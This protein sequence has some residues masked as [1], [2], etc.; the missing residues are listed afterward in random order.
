MLASTAARVTFIGLKTQ[1]LV[2]ANVAF[3]KGYDDRNRPCCS[4]YLVSRDEYLAGDDATYEYD[5]S[6]TVVIRHVECRQACVE[7]L[8]ELSDDLG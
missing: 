1:Y 2:A 6:V 4:E 8:G 3:L 7:I 5:F